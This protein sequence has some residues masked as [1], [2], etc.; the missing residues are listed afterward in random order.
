MEKTVRA[1]V[2]QASSVV[3]DRE[4]SIDKL[5]QLT[6]KAAALGAELVVFPEAFVSAYPKGG[7]R[8]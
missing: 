5:H 8:G 1:A 7:F 3:F 4:K 6:R 2:V